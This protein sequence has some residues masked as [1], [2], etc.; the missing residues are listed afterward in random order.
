MDTA[1]SVERGWS[2]K[3]IVKKV[4]PHMRVCACVRVKK[5]SLIDTIDSEASRLRFVDWS[6]Q[7]RFAFFRSSLTNR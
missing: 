7:N 1:V 5:R 6:A 2:K 4:G 3:K